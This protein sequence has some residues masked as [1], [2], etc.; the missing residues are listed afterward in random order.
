VVPTSAVFKTSEGADYILLAGSDGHAHLKTVQAGVH[1]VEFTQIVSGVNAG[2]SVIV[3]GGY[4][5]PDNTQIKVE[6]PAPAEKDAADKSEKP[7]KSGDTAKPAA[8]DKE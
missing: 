6:V 7:E 1:N 5:L 3:S 2:D 8:K 4:A